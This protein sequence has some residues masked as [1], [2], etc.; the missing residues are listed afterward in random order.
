M[1]RVTAAWETVLKGRNIRKVELHWVSARCSEGDWQRAPA[2][3]PQWVKGMEAWCSACLLC[4]IRLLPAGLSSLNLLS[5][6]KAEDTKI[7]SQT[8]SSLGLQEYHQRLRTGVT[9][10]LTPITLKQLSMTSRQ[11]VGAEEIAPLCPNN[12][13]MNNLW[14]RMQAPGRS[15]QRNPFLSL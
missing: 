15:I 12:K 2:Y 6:S 4:L 8:W 7:L 11:H 9:L 5:S 13:Q 1:V 3:H 10:F 14:T